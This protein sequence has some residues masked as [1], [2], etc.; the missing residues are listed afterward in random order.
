[1]RRTF[2]QLLLSLA[3][4]TPVVSLVGCAEM[5]ATV[6]RES[7]EEGMRLYHQKMY[8]DATGAFRN[9]VKQEPRDYQSHFYLA[10]CYDELKQHQ[11]AFQQ[12][13]LGVEMM[14][15]TAEGRHD[16]EFRNWPSMLMCWPVARD[17]RPGGRTKPA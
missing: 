16:D 17:R 11:P 14:N 12:Y 13:R 1:M 8:G 5:F 15:T 10:V 9:A 3:L 6:S 7:N 4:F 2:G